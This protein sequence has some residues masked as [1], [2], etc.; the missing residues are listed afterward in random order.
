MVP[1]FLLENPADT[2]SCR[3]SGDL[4]ACLYC[5]GS[6]RGEGSQREGRRGGNT[7]KEEGQGPGAE[8]GF[9]EKDEV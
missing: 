4:C 5:P 1:E 2:R 6:H 7:R 9:R 3:G 8:G